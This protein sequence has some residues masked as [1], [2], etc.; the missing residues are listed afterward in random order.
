MYKIKTTLLFMIIILFNGC[1]YPLYKY[2]YKFNITN[3]EELIE[4]LL[5]KASSQIFPNMNMNEV[6]LVSNFVETTTLKSNTKLS[7]VLSDMLKNQLV[8]KYSYTVKDIELS[9]QFKLGK[10]GFKVLTRDSEKTYNKISNSRYVI[11][12]MYTFTNNQILLFLKLINIKNGNIL[13]SSNYVTDLTKDIV[14]LN[15]MILKDP[16]KKE[17]PTQQEIYQP[18]VL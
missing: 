7:F 5:S 4:N 17:M 12:G 16:N 1:N 10:E 9:N 18:M 14:E 6:L 3:Y 13:A 15:N 8:S 2:N 11:A